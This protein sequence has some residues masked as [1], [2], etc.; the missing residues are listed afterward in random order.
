[1]KLLKVF[2][3][4]TF[5]TTLLCFESSHA[6]NG[7]DGRNGAKGLNGGHG[8]DKSIYLTDID[9]FIKFELSGA[10]GRDGGKGENGGAAFCP[11]Y[12]THEYDGGDGGKGGN[13][14]RGGD[15]GDLIAYYDEVDLPHLSKILFISLGGEGGIGGQGG[16]GG[17]GCYYA[18]NGRNGRDGKNGHDGKDGR[19][20]LVPLKKLPENFTTLPSVILNLSGS[21]KKFISDSPTVQWNSWFANSGATELLHPDSLFQDTY[22]VYSHQE[23]RTIKMEWNAERDIE[24]F[25]NKKLTLNYDLY[26]K[27][28][29]SHIESENKH[30]WFSFSGCDKNEKSK[31]TCSI[32]D[33]LFAS[34]LEKIKDRGFELHPGQLSWMFEDLAEANHMVN[35][36][37]TITL[38]VPFLYFFSK[39]VFDDKEIKIVDNVMSG[40]GARYDSKTIT[41]DLNEFIPEEYLEPG[42]TLYLYADVERSFNARTVSGDDNVYQKNFSFY[43]E[44]SL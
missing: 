27:G 34:E 33:A 9:S 13:G 42:N 30:V 18:E 43:Q 11:T 8:K 24:S 22:Y 4:F 40:V 10:D 1:M 28:P 14:G 12:Y 31:V 39:T 29:V 21:L 38:K 6:N 3:S 5:F 19:L 36:K 17:E 2:L 37:I 41:V 15:G 44:I 23:I 35:T 32:E 20:F 16:V 25:L 26:G 7:V